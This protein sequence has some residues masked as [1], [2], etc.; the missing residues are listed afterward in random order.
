VEILCMDAI[1]VNGGVSPPSLL[2]EGHVA[3]NHYRVRSIVSRGTCW[4][5]SR[6]NLSGLS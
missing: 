6:T 2:C 3:Q 1:V 5:S 4:T